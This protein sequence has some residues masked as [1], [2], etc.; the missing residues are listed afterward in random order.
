MTLGVR[1]D[2]FHDDFTAVADKL[3]ETVGRMWP[4]GVK[5][6]PNKQKK[7]VHLRKHCHNLSALGGIRTLFHPHF[8]GLEMRL[9]GK[10]I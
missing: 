3:A 6:Q 4:R 7:A 1:A 8:T 5:R 9:A 2:L 10:K